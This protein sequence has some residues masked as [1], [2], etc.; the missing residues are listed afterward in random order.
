MYLDVSQP[1]ASFSMASCS[2][3]TPWGP[4][5]CYVPSAGNGAWNSVSA[6]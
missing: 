2:E 6:V 5:H 1:L 4:V 3:G